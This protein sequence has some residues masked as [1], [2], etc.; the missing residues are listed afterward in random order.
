LDASVGAGTSEEIY[1]SIFNQ[2]S[3]AHMVAVFDAFKEISEGKEIEETIQSEFSG[4]LQTAYLA[5]GNSL[6][7]S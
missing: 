7:I 2:R 1:Q 3:H 4:S 6:V 5:F